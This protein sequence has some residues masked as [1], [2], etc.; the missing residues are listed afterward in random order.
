[1]AD[2]AHSV[3]INKAMLF[4]INET[5]NSVVNILSNHLP[6]INPESRPILCTRIK[7]QTPTKVS[8]TNRKMIKTAMMLVAIILKL[9]GRHDPDVNG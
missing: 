3:C 7:A 5:I 9:S 1:M 6:L 4:T 8:S 2:T